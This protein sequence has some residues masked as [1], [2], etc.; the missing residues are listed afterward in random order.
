MLHEYGLV[1]V[2]VVIISGSKQPIVYVLEIK[3]INIHEQ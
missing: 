3:E 2:Y 1:F